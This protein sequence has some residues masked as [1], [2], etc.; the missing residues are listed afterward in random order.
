ML[1]QEALDTASQQPFQVQRED[2]TMK[3]RLFS[4]LA[5]GAGLLAHSAALKASPRPLTGKRVLIHLKTGF[6]QDDNQPCVAFDMALAALKQ[7]AR[8]EMFFDAAAV[9]DLKIWQGKP[10]R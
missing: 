9:V 1:S 8:V 7:G 4:I 10:T 6:K 2:Q 5:L 3:V